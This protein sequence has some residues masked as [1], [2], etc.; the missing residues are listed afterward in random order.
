MKP[1]DL[2]PPRILVVD[3]DQGQRSL[4][5]TFLRSRGYRT[6]SAA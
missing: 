2:K 5:E 3:D 4:L 6:Q 1:S